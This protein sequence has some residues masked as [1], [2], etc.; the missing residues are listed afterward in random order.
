MQAPRMSKIVG[1]DLGTTHSAIAV[2][3]AGMPGI[4]ADAE[5][6]RLLPSVVNFPAN[7]EP[8][9]GVAAKRIQTVEPERTV[10]S[11]K[12]FMGRL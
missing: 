1:I 9:V 6:R 12:R 7:G 11:A 2:V 5:G 8:V 4:L 3:E 10:S